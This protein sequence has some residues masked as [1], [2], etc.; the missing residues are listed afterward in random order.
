MAQ[1]IR[2]LSHASKGGGFGAYIQVL[3]L[4]QG[5]RQPIDVSLFPFLKLTTKK[6]QPHL[7]KLYFLSLRSLPSNIENDTYR[8]KI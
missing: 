1:L 3:G 5:G 4:I 8:K 6:R 7:K 2:V